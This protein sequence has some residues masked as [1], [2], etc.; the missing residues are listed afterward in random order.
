MKCAD[1][2]IASYLEAYNVVR[3]VTGIGE[4]KGPYVSVH[5]AFYSQDEWAGFMP[6]ADRFAL[7]FHKYAC[8]GPQNTN[9]LAEI[10]KV[11]CQ[12]YGELT[13]RSMSNFGLTTAGEFSNAVNDCGL[14][15]N[16]VGK[17]TRYEGEFPGFDRV[18]SCDAWL[19]YQSWDAETK[20]NYMTYTQGHMD[21]FQVC[22]CVMVGLCCKSYRF[23]ILL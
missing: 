13:N 22:S 16:G 6:G 14:Y 3:G 7:D 4:G 19:D 5:D 9:P 1:L 10:A 23:L 18:G 17:G 12:A 11:P 21:A 15:V 8:F 20:K 2:L